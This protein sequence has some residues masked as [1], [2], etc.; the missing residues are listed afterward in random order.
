MGKGL[1]ARWGVWELD[2]GWLQAFFN[3]CGKS[4]GGH[5][6]QTL[7]FFVL[8]ALSPGYKFSL[9]VASMSNLRF[10]YHALTKR[11]LY[12]KYRHFCEVWAQNSRHKRA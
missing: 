5:F 10:R 7:G 12:M 3:F 8:L 1:Q 11:S 9:A 6:A 4:K 2:A